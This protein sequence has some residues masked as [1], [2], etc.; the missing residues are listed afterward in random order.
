MATMWRVLPIVVLL[1]TFASAAEPTATVIYLKEPPAPNEILK[2]REQHKDSN[3]LFILPEGF[4]LRENVEFARDGDRVLAMDIMYPAKSAKPVPLLMEIT[5]DNV[6][7]MGSGSLLFCH[8]TLLEGATAAGFAVAM[9]DHPVRP[10]YKG[11]DDPMPEC[12]ERM[13]LAVKKLREVGPE[14]GISEKIGAIGFS[15]GAPFAAILA[16]QGGQGGQGG[17]QAALVHG[18]RFDYLDLLPNDPMLG[19]FE[20][21]WGKRDEN[22]DKW[23]AHGA[24]QYLSPKAAPMFLNTSAAESPEYRDGLAKFDA[25]LTKRHIEHVYQVDQ[26]GRGH[27]ISTDPKTLAKI[28]Q[29]FHQH[30]DAPAVSNAPAAGAEKRN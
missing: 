27:R 7:R 28:Y 4:Q 6:N 5:C 26:D 17:V 8:D 15:R 13:K 14:L 18:N 20:R 2:L 21:A 23:L 3:R 29:F 19:R 11:I 24:V 12:I 22:R 30:L 10:P 1:C 25:E 9:V 16:G